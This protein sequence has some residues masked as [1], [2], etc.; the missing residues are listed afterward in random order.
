MFESLQT[1]CLKVLQILTLL[2]LMSF[3]FKSK[4]LCH[5]LYNNILTLILTFL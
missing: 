4:N 1:I 2:N 5:C 3:K